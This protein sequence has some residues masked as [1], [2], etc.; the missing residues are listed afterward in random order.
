MD[1]YSRVMHYDTSC[2]IYKDTGIFAWTDQNHQ[3]PPVGQMVIYQL[4]QG[5]YEGRGDGSWVDPVTGVNCGF[6]WSQNGRKGDFVQLRKKL[7]YIES[8]GVNTIELLPVNEF[9]GDHAGDIFPDFLHRGG[10]FRV[11]AACHEDIRTF[12]N[13]PLSSG[14]ADA[15]ITTGDES[16]FS[17]QLAHFFSHE[18]RFRLSGGR[19][20]L[21]SAHQQGQ[22][23]L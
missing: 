20:G 9:P 18:A 7:D 19:A 6:T 21:V 2:S 10:K 1:P 5:G 16:D 8:L 17:I 14:E 12:A 3:P 23:A 4:F 15:A 22:F 13:E 11:A